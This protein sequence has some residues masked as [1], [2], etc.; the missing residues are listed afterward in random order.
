MILEL[1]KSLAEKAGIASSPEYLKWAASPELDALKNIEIPEEILKPFNQNL[2]NFETAKTHKEIRKA[3][4]G[5]E[6][7]AVDQ[8]ILSVLIE[9]GATD[10]KQKEIMSIGTTAQKAKAAAKFAHELGGNSKTTPS[11]REKRL[12]E[13]FSEQTKKYESAQLERDQEKKSFQ[14][15][16]NGIKI[17]YA[18]K[19]SLMSHSLRDDL[20]REDVELLSQSKLNKWL[21][22]N[23]A[24]L[25]LTPGESLEIMDADE[26]STPYFDKTTNTHKKFND[27]FPKLL[28]D[29]KMLKA[30]DN[31]SNQKQVEGEVNNNANIYI[32]PYQAQ[33]NE[34]IKAQLSS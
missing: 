23:K 25:V 11:E 18:L 3:I 28:A 9:L 22:E 33:L 24:T 20:G 19:N 17:N 31:K 7:G 30:S 16:L 27:I 1:I 26:P 13:Q 34:V 21:A 10:E 8:D 6:L 32:P 15:E 2:I 4:K 5:E 14:K 12:S 29:N